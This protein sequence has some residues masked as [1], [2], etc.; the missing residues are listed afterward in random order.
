M[1]NAR[2]FARALLVVVL[3]ATATAR[4]QNAPPDPATLHRLQA[5]TAMTDGMTKLM[6]L[7][8]KVGTAVHGL[9]VEG[10]KDLSAQRQIDLLAETQVKGLPGTKRALRV[11]GGLGAGYIKLGQIL[12]TRGDDLMQPAYEAELETLTDRAPPIALATVQMIIRRELGPVAMRL[13]IEPKPAGVGSVGQ[14]HF[15]DFEVPGKGQRRIVIKVIKPEAAAELD[16]NL[17]TMSNALAKNAGAG[18]GLRPILAELKRQVVLETDLREEGKAIELASPAM[19]ARGF[20]LAPSLVAGYQPTKNVLLEEVVPGASIFDNLPK[21]RPAAANR[22]FQEVVAQILEDGFVHG[23]PTRGN[24]FHFKGGLTFLDWGLH[25]RI[26]PEDRGHLSALAFQALN[27]DRDAVI[28]TVRAMSKS[29]IADEPKLAAALKDLFQ[30]Q[31][32]PGRRLQGIVIHAQKAG[33]TIPSGIVWSSKAL[34]QAEGLAKKLDRGF[35]A[36]EALRAYGKS[37]F[38]RPLV[39]KKVINHLP[40]STREK[41]LAPLSFAPSA[42]AKRLF[43]S[44]RPA[45]K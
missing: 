16:R 15:A 28:E 32:A 36:S 26:T 20:A 9:L 35:K 1:S 12:A 31:A 42:I 40:A 22:L 11:F 25:G 18:E 5:F 10:F 44:H 6:F 30:R 24:V 17:T 2:P 14:T 43:G 21:D 39:M 27:G 38:L 3:M 23:D 41:L 19:K 7:D 29:G 34:F 45:K 13:K 33:A 37:L 8:A 4:A